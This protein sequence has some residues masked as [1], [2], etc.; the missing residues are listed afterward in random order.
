MQLTSSPISRS[1]VVYRVYAL[2]LEN[3]SVYTHICHIYE[4]VYVCATTSHVFKTLVSR[5]IRHHKKARYIYICMY[6][7]LFVYQRST[8]NEKEKTKPRRFFL[9][10]DMQKNIRFVWWTHN[11]TAKS[12]IL[13]FI[14][15]EKY[16]FINITTVIVITIIILIC[17]TIE[18]KIQPVL[19]TEANKLL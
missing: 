4:D 16:I 12:S 13:I 5:P 17:A 11:S 2:E 7:V 9:Q 6:I 3:S 15:Q 14:K 8:S 10:L 1:Y 19:V 18:I